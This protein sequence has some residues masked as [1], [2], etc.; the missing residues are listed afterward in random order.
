MEKQLCRQWNTT[1][2]NKGEGSH[3]GTECCKTPPE[4]RTS[5]DG[6]QE[7]CRQILRSGCWDH[8]IL[9][10]CTS[11][12]LKSLKSLQRQSHTWIL[13]LLK[14]LQRQSHTWARHLD[15]LDC[16]EPELANVFISMISTIQTHAALHAG[17]PTSSRYAVE[18][19][20]TH[21]HWIRTRTRLHTLQKVWVHN[22]GLCS[23]RAATRLVPNNFLFFYSARSRTYPVPNWTL[24]LDRRKEHLSLCALSFYPYPA[25]HI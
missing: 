24:F 10:Q 20:Y 25:R 12:I 13:K 6:D 15:L 18:K 19:W 16:H 14:S 1:P 9:M 4:K 3:G 7:G 11:I 17:M 23:G 8:C 21:A 22:K 5:I 2:H